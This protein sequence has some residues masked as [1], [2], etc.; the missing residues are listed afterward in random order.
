MTPAGPPTFTDPDWLATING[1]AE[2]RLAA[3]G[4]RL[5][6][7]V[8]QPHVRP[9]STVLRIPTDRGPVWCKAMVAGTAH[10]A[11][12]LA[13]FATWNVPWVLGPLAVDEGRAWMLLEDGGPTLR[14]TRP[15]GEGD[16]DLAAWEDI[17]AAYA[18]LQR[19][20]EG[21]A[22]DLLV[23]GVPDVRPEVLPG[24]LDRVVHTDR[25]WELVGDADRPATDAARRRLR[26]MGAWSVEAAAELAGSG[27]RPSIQHDD[28]HG[29]NVFVGPAGIR[30]FDWGDSVVAHPFGS[31]LTTLN[32]IAYRLGTEPDDPRLQRLRDAYLEGWTDLLPRPALA[33]VLDRAIELGR[34]GKAAAWARALDDIDPA[35][36][37]GHGD[38]PAL[39]LADLVER[40]DRRTG[41]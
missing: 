39:W 23:Q 37:Q 38:A 26:T 20:V 24:I 1:W 16:R 35:D 27:I 17:L 33:D 32:S 30:F 19:Q 10:E 22:D 12:L 18:D 25:W 31:L 13:A 8:E 4:Y 15:D 40:L 21:R 41:G 9:W 11:K 14:Q 2:E 3:L 28:L 29:G 6:G 34:I 7:V 36:M 5:V